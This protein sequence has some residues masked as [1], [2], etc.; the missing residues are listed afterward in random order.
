MGQNSCWPLGDIIIA[1]HVP[2]DAAVWTRDADFEPI[3]QALG[4]GLYT[5]T[6]L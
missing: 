1:L 6:E 5:P 2:D 3:A 4:L